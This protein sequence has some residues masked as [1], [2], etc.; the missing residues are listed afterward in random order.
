MLR[1]GQLAWSRSA[2]GEL[3]YFASLQ[4]AKAAFEAA[5]T[6]DSFVDFHA[7]QF[8][9]SSFRLVASDLDACGFPALRERAF[10]E[11]DAPEFYIVLSRAE[12]GC[13]IDRL[14]LLERAVAE[15][16]GIATRSNPPSPDDVAT[17]LAVIA[18]LEAKLAVAEREKEAYAEQLAALTASLSWRL[19]TSRRRAANLVRRW[20]LTS[21]I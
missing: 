12:Y 11:G 3:R 15:E 4:S 13:P 6:S 21:W 9:P 10:L 18:T 8:T 20:R 7:W 5:L 16:A 1:A 2:N 19:T 14:T 17:H